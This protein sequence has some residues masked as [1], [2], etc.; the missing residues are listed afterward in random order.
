[1]SDRQ[2]QPAREAEAE[3]EAEPEPEA[4]TEVEV[5]LRP[6]CTRR[7]CS[8]SKPI[9]IAS[10]VAASIFGSTAGCEMPPPDS[11]RLAWM[12]R[13]RSSSPPPPGGAP[14]PGCGTDTWMIE[15]GCA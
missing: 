1:M 7:T 10:T 3:A 15:P 5:K 4:R 12:A 6:A 11:A 13:A 2:P 14:P 9:E 8:S